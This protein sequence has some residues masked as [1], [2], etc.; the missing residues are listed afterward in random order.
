MPAEFKPFVSLI[1][2]SYKA[3]SFI[4]EA[5]DGALA[6]TYKNIEIIFSDDASPDNTFKI[7]EQEV[8]K[9][10]GI[11]KPAIRILKNAKNIGIAEH[12]NKLWWKEAK[13]EWIIVSA[14]DDVSL[15]NR[16]EKLIPHMADDVGV[17][18]HDSYLIDEK[19]ILHD[20]MSDYSSLQSIIDKN[21]VEELIEHNVYLKGST[22][23]LSRKMLNLFG[24]FN[25]DIINEDIIL[26]YRAQYFGK[27][28]HVK[29][30]LLK[31][32][33][34]P[35]SISQAIS[36]KR[37]EGYRQEVK[38]NALRN[39]A[40]YNQVMKDN[41]ILKLNAE[42]LSRLSRKNLSNTFYLFFYGDDK[43]KFA[44]LKFPEFYKQMM[45]RILLKPYLYFKRN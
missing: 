6:Q 3:E 2:M 19:S 31:Y 30:K 25:A 5:I 14:G 11:H 1:I 26:A 7:I 10:D 21:S 42:F 40:V 20:L 41:E 17:I 23:C 36:T 29:E 24:P 22:M 16:I 8:A 15:P 37:F 13:G 33:E 35:N 39:R 4:K 32:R 44:F 9:Y 34:H 28:V 27:I 43:F 12:I 38:K 18:H 45:K